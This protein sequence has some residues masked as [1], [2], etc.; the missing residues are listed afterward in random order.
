M[1]IENSKVFDSKAQLLKTVA[2]RIKGKETIAF[3]R[4]KQESRTIIA[5]KIYAL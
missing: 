2:W 5:I 1:L 3:V 4:Y